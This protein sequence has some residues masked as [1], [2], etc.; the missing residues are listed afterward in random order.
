MALQYIATLPETMTVSD[1]VTYDVVSDVQ[2]AVIIA[3]RSGL[4]ELI[5]D[6]DSGFAAAWKGF[7][8]L[9]ATDTGFTLT[10]G[11]RAFNAAGVAVLWSDAASS[12]GGGGG[13]APSGPAGGDLDGTYPN[14]TIAKLQGQTLNLTG[15]ADGEVI[16]RVAGVWQAE[17]DEGGGTTDDISNASTA[18]GTTLTDALDGLYS[19]VTQIEGGWKRVVDTNFTAKATQA[20]TTDGEYV[21]DGVKYQISNNARASAFGIIN[22]TGWQ[23]SCN[24]NQSANYFLDASTGPVIAIKLKD[25]CPDFVVGQSEVRM[26]G[27]L[28]SNGNQ[29]HENVGFGVALYPWN[30]GGST[31][32]WYHIFAAGAY[33]SINPHNG[34]IVG[35]GSSGSGTSR[36]DLN[37][38]SVTVANDPTRS[39]WGIH[40]KDLGDA[41]FYTRSLASSAPNTGTNDSISKFEQLSLRAQQRPQGT[42]AS[43]YNNN[44]AQQLLNPVAEWLVDDA[45]DIQLLIMAVSTYNTSAHMVATLKRLVVEY[46]P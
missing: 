38:T 3:R 22:G 33:D 6:A 43:N 24:A 5:Y 23:I 14:P 13:G 41:N 15:A 16:K 36:A 40:W 39:I 25:I 18:P 28:G 26:W 37:L 46:K 21:I 4:D 44:Q 12:G 19:Q 20:T 29:N 42:S 34:I 9:T 31:P 11:R 10:L 8:S 45:G 7:S 27:L 17:P 35:H 32:N 1:T 2:P 30:G